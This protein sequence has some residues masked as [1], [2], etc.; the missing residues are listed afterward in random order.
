MKKLWKLGLLTILLIGAFTACQKPEEKLDS[1]V[2]KTWTPAKDSL[3]LAY[4]LASS[5]VNYTD[6]SVKEMVGSGLYT[7]HFDTTLQAEFV[8]L[9][10][11][12]KGELQLQTIM[13]EAIKTMVQV[14]EQQ[15]LAFDKALIPNTK[16]TPDFESLQKQGKIL[17]D[18]CLSVKKKYTIAFA[19]S[20]SAATNNQKYFKDRLDTEIRLF[21]QKYVQQSK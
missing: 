11:K 12:Q 7:R 10:N 19:Q 5:T 18:S 2:T 21:N 14:V 3:F 6:K 1:F 8:S 15:D 20:Q 9:G 17:A 16:P 4:K 13:L